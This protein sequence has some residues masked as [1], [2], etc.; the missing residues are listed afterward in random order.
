MT[1]IQPL[2]NLPV[3][4]LTR[5]Y[6]GRVVNVEIDRSNQQIVFY[7]VRPKWKLINLWQKNILISPRQVIKITS[8]SMVVDEN[9]SSLSST[10]IKLVSE[11]S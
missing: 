6:I 3:Y 5:F 10:P 11:S 9:W 1:K 2:L 8:E 4:T 7:A